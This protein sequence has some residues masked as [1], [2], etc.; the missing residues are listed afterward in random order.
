MTYGG[1]FL[2]S[3]RHEIIANNHLKKW[4][5]VREVKRDSQLNVDDLKSLIKVAAPHLSWAIEV[6]WMCRRQ[7]W[8]FGTVIVAMVGSQL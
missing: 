1:V 5:K 7:N 8:K 6:E 2:I 4:K 3:H